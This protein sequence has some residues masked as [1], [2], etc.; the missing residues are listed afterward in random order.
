M[1]IYGIGTDIANINRIK[2]SLNKKNFVERVFNNIEIARC[3]RQ[4]NKV[5]CC[6][7]Y[8]SISDRCIN[9]FRKYQ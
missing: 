9:N 8:G 6:I 3:N 7:I 1:K 4:K 5:N 2:N